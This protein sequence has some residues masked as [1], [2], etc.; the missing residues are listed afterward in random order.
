MQ[1]TRLCAGQRILFAE[2]DWMVRFVLSQLLREEGFSVV[3]AES[4]DGAAAVL[5][6]ESFDCLL[7]DVRMPGK[8]DGIHLAA[9]ARHR[10]PRLPVVVISGYADRIQA[11]VAALGERVLLV[12]K[13]FRLAEILAALDQVTAPVLVSPAT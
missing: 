8:M 7:T 1:S 6:H 11:R 2:D 13:P 10:E 12:G 5:E 9:H 3:E 4:G